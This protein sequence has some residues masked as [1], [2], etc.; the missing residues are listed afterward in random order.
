[1]NEIARYLGT[2]LGTAPQLEKGT[3]SVME[4]Q[5]KEPSKG[6]M[7]SKGGESVCSQH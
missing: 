3:P 6:A 4:W 1:M 5:E 2:V 7:C